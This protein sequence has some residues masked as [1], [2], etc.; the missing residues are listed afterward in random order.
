MPPMEASPI[1]RALRRAAARSKA[2]SSAAAEDDHIDDSEQAPQEVGST[3][4]LSTQPDS[5]QTSRTAQN[6]IPDVYRF[7]IVKWMVADLEANGQ[8]NLMARAIRQFPQHFRSSYNANIIRAMRYW[9]ARDAILSRHANGNRSNNISFSLSSHNGIK[10]SLTKA[11]PGRGRKRTQWV[12]ILY[13]LL[14]AEFDRLRKSGVRFDSRLLRQ[15]ALDILANSTNAECNNYTVDATSGLNIREHIKSAWVGRFMQ[16]NNVVVRAQTGKLLISPAKLEIIHRKVAYHL[17]E[18]AR[19]FRSGRLHEQDLFNADETH[20]VIHLHNSRTLAKRGESEVK[21]ADVVSGD[22]G[23]TLMVLL[24]GGCNAQMGVPMIIFKNASRSY[25]IRGVQDDTPGITYRSSPKGWMDSALFADWLNSARIFQPL[26]NN[27]TRVMYVDNCSAHKL[28]PVTQAAIQRS[29]T[30]LRFFPA[31]AT[32][33]VQPADSFVIQR[34]KSEWRARWDKKVMDMIANK[35]W[36]DPRD[37]SGRLV[38][39]GKK[40]FLSMA[41]DV[42]RTVGQQRD[43]DGILYTR[44]ALVRCGMA[45]NYNGLW[46]ERQLS[47]E[48]QNI[49]KKYAENFNG[50]PVTTDQDL[51]GERTDTDEES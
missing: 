39:P 9:K 27:R 35:M 18:L 17:G 44:K 29:R 48:L 21:Y 19:D 23:M 33:M 30:E 45:L 37:G 2:S 46:E 31:C 12:Q 47:P 42:V 20:C 11:R 41:A 15:L 34:I 1:V 7:R 5:A 50:Q 16:I 3:T 24:G 10:K 4:T 13:P 25:P 38:N 40:F 8:K 26:P 36:T 32:D 28:T 51:D 6:V 22:E 14:I 49:V 43:Q